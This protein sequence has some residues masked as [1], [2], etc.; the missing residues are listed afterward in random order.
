MFM[1]ISPRNKVR[2]GK[3]TTPHKDKLYEISSQ[4]GI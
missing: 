2:L 1:G 3:V 4:T